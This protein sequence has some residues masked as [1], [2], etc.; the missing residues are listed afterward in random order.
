[1]RRDKSLE[2]IELVNVKSATIGG[3]LLSNVSRRC[4]VV[5]GHSPG[6]AIDLRHENDFGTECF[7]HPGA[8]RTV[9]GRHRNDQWMA[10]ARTNDGEPGAH[11]SPG[12][13]DD[14]RS[15]L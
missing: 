7:E 1:M 2:C 12:H 3:Q 5:T 15:S 11:I 8:L 14:R 10:K 6:F 9:A 4:D 13:F